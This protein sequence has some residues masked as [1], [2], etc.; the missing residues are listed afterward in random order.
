MQLNENSN[1]LGQDLNIS[2]SIINCKY[3]VIKKK[4][5][6]SVGRFGGF[7]GVVFNRRF[8]TKDLY[9]VNLGVNYGY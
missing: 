1:Y 3:S 2:Y 7:Y 4:M 5:V 9:S 8:L 6:G